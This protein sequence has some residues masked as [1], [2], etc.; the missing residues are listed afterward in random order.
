MSTNVTMIG[1]VP[2]FQL[3]DEE[4]REAL[5]QMMDCRDY[6]DGEVLF[7]YGDPGGEIFILRQGKV[8]LSI[9]SNDGE[10]IILAE[11]E[12]GDVLGELSFL[13]GGPRTATAIARAETHTL[14]M[15][16]DRLMDFIDKHPHAAMDLLTVVGRRLRTT[17]DLLRTRVSRN[18]NVEEEEM[19]TLGDRVADRVASFGGSWTFILIFGAIM[20]VWVLL[21]TTFLLR[22]HFDPYPFILLNLFLS[23]IAA[24]QAPVIMMSQNR[25]ASKDRLKADLDYDVNLKAELE[26][27]QLHRK[28]DNMY[29][30]LE[31]RFARI[32]AQ[33]HHR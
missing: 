33:N 22:N 15:H 23:M 26:V 19:M 11:N 32:D 8:E 13:D 14:S 1:E 10:K 9:E 6:V 29:E 30:R 12:Q 18:V 31:E 28:L 25:Q 7:N 16:R 4:E 5:A 27:A 21:N 2:I 24:I 20:V 17:D 3:L